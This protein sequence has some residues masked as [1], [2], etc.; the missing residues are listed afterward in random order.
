[1]LFPSCAADECLNWDPD[2]PGRGSDVWSVS[3]LWVRFRSVSIVTIFTHLSRWMALLYRQEVFT[4]HI[5]M[6]QS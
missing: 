2:L 4:A 6:D 3:R 1:M 5:C